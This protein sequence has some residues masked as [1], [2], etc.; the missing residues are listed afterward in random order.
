[1]DNDSDRARSTVDTHNG[2]K[3]GRTDDKRSSIKRPTSA[4]SWAQSSD[5]V[6]PNDDGDTDDTDAD[7][8][9]STNHEKI[10]DVVGEVQ[11]LEQ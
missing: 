1:M 11:A 9:L 8:S 5:N 10:N 7:G 4:I 3:N 6:I 2:S